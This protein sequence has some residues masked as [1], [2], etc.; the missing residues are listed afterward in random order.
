MGRQA[1]WKNIFPAKKCY[2]SARIDPA[3]LLCRDGGRQFLQVGAI[4]SALE[5]FRVRGNF[6]LN[7]HLSVTAL[8]WALLMS[9]SG[10]SPKPLSP[11]AKNAPISC[12]G[13]QNQESGSSVQQVLFT[14]SERV[15][16]PR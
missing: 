11:R 4:N 3:V 16:H 9:C 15:G 6:P 14:S 13:G 8:P 7:G 5:Q 10:P 12:L 2:S 1:V